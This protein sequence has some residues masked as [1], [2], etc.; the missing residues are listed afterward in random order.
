MTFA[1]PVALA[2]LALALAPAT[3]RADDAPV[4]E[5]IIV[6]VKA[7]VDAAERADIRED[8]D[9]ELERAMRLANT[10][11]VN[12]TEGSREDALAELRSDPDVLWAAPNGTAHALTNDAWFSNQWALFNDGLS[13]RRVDADVDAEQAWTITRGA[14]ITVGVVDS[15]VQSTHPDLAGRLNLVDAKDFVD[16][17]APDDGD[18]H[19]THVSGIIG[20]NR[21]NAIGISG[22]APEA[23]LLPVRAL[24]DN[25]DGS[26]DHVLDAFDWAAD[27]GAQVVNASIGGPYHSTLQTAFDQIYAA[28]PTTTFVIAAG[29]DS[30]NNDLSP[31]RSLPCVT[32]AANVLC[33]G[34]TTNTDARATFSN[35][36][37]TTVDLFAPGNAIIST[38]PTGA[39]ANLSGTSMA[40]PY[41]AGAAALVAEELGLRGAALAQ[42][43]KA[44]VDPVAGLAGLAVTGGRLNAA[45]AVGATVDAPT[46][47]HIDSVQGGAG[48]AT[49]V[50]RSRESD[51]ATYAVYSSV[52]GYLGTTT[53]PTISIGGLPA[54][55]RAFSVVARNTSGQ[56]SPASAPVAVSVG[57]TPPAPAPST[58]APAPARPGTIGIPTTTAP[59]TGPVTGVQVVTRG[60]RRSLVFRV[61]RTS[62]VTVTLSR[63]RGSGYRKASEKTVRM[64]AGLQSLPITS[65]LLGMKVPTGRWRVTVGSG[66]AVATVAFVRR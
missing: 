9:T 51:I 43:L 20:A 15:G 23:T 46:Q 22:I 13:G 18:G 59:T 41:V 53:S 52:D 36:G 26:W 2:L 47:P 34:A 12:V 40:A 21:G 5:Q 16:G 60:G 63:L 4:S 66:T 45:R 49:I 1:R 57:A 8:S 50:M 24:D 25:G 42:R 56:D 54:G 61:T 32:S 48:T 35:Y 62:R 39:Y 29:N 58:P 14:G 30:L 3:A 28:H 64:A 10:E 44:T 27:H 65:R 6:R 37:T 31:V 38:F 7:G 11:L 33:V 55:T 17:G 19:G